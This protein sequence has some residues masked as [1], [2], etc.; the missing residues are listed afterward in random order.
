MAIA[1]G[2]AQIRI[3]KDKGV[4]KRQLLEEIKRQQHTQAMASFVLCFI[5][6]A[7]VIALV[8]RTIYIGFGKPIYSIQI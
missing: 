4:Y 3:N 5:S 1:I 7:V 6:R 2:D 8:P